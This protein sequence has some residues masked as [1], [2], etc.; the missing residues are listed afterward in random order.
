M[1]KIITRQR[2]YGWCAFRDPEPVGCGATQAAAIA[3]L[4]RKEANEADY[5]GWCED[6]QRRADAKEGFES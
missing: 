1:R 4:K 3:D 6:A 5:A 2:L